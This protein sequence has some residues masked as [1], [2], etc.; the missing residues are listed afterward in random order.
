MSAPAYPLE[1][2]QPNGIPDPTPE[3]AKA[4]V[5]AGG[6]GTRLAP[7]TSILPKPLMPIGNRSI[8]EIVVEQLGDFGFTDVTFSVG[9]LS[10][11]IRAVFET[12]ADP[13]VSI[14][15]VHE[16]QP[17]GTAG[18]LRLIDGLDTTFMAMN[19]D[20]LTTLDYRDLVRH[21]CEAGNALTIATRRRTVKIDY[22]VLYVQDEAPGGPLVEAFEEKPEI[23]ASVSMG[24][25]VFEPHALEYIPPHTY[26]DFPDV[27]QALL[28][29]GERV[30]AYQYDGV[31]FDIGRHDDYEQAVDAWGSTERRVAQLV[32]EE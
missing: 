23:S 5:L 21:H 22:G 9:Y 17:L 8:L 3:T 25:Y 32:R 16:Q 30:G 13:R 27:V 11:L 24:V 18:P 2:V 26:F 10:H 15:Y 1:S 28:L 29:A 7:Y 4:V 14:S 31:W 19:G 6:R 20:I 12:Y